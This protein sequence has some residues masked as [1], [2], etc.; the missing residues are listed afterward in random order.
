MLIYYW[1]KQYKYT[2]LIIIKHKKSTFIGNAFNEMYGA[3]IP[4]SVG[5]TLGEYYFL[6]KWQNFSIN[7]ILIFHFYTCK[8]GL[9]EQLDGNGRSFV[10]IIYYTTSELPDKSHHSQQ[11]NWVLLQLH[12]KQRIGIKF[13]CKLVFTKQ[14]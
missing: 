8:H 9:H 7:S 2:W 6:I 14:I 12:W 3:F 13:T 11:F 10:I 1:S 4:L 5:V